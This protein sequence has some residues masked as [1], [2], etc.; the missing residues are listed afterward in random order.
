MN[1][2]GV[3]TSSKKTEAQKQFSN[4]A[5]DNAFIAPEVLFTKFSDHN[6]AMD[7][8]SFGMMMYSLLLGREPISF[9]EVYRRW[10]KRQHGGYDIELS[11]LPFISPSASNF[12]YDP[13]S[14]DLD[15]PFSKM[16][17]ELELTKD[18]D[19]T[20]SLVD[21]QGSGFNFENV[22]KCIKNLSLSSLF[23]N[24]NSKKFSFKSMAQEINDN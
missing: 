13:F 18:L 12:L 8:W 6:S 19:I 11:Q 17:D 15:N 9:Y 20:G 10:Y 2:G 23:E 14:I 21:K 1:H 3:G 5:L 7:V 4:R 24:G 22:M 16:E